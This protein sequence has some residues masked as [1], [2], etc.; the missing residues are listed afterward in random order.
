MATSASYNF[1]LNR[2]EIIKTALEEV[3][4][5]DIFDEVPEEYISLAN[6]R[7]NMMIK[8]W[9][10]RGI[11]LPFTEEIIIFLPASTS[12]LTISPT[13]NHTCL[14]SDFVSTTLS[15]AASGGA[16]S[17]TVA[18][19]TGLAI[20]DNI[21]IALSDGTR[22]WTTISN[23]SGTTVTLADVLTESAESGATVY[24]YTNKVQKPMRL[25]QARRRSEGVDIP[26]EILARADWFSLATKTNS[27]TVT[28]I[29]YQPKLSTGLLYIW[30]QTDNVDDY[31]RCTVE[32]PAEDFDSASDDCM[33]PSEWYEA[34]VY[35][36]AWRLGTGGKFGLTDQEVSN[37]KAIADEAFDKVNAFDQE[38]TYVDFVPNLDGRY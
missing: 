14:A 7:L 28:Q 24:A 22:Q 30:Q 36:L 23:V 19:G 10:T 25:L 38:Y 13:G 2:N 3:A 27:G 18:S 33:Y 15:A 29:H 34:I 35:G 5:A 16:S 8:S 1:S 21:G 37:L 11:S 17:L 20:S 26:V 4:A 31:L 6:R 32:Y 12:E 9:Q